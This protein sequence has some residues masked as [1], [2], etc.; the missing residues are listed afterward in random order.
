M[1]TKKT[2]P[3]NISQP[4]S[5][6]IYNFEGKDYV[7]KHDL[8]RLDYLQFW[9]DNPRTNLLNPPKAQNAF[10]QVFKEDSNVVDL[11]K[12]LRHQHQLE[13]LIV[14]R[15]SQNQFIV[16]EGNSRLAAMKLIC[17]EL[18]HRFPEAKCHVAPDRCPD[19]VLE[20]I[21]DERH[22]EDSPIKKWT[23]FGRGL[24][25]A[26][27]LKK[28][29]KL[30]LV[31]EIVNQDPQEILICIKTSKVLIKATPKGQE[32]DKERFSAVKAV[33]SFFQRQ[34]TFKRK[35]SYDCL[36]SIALDQNYGG[37]GTA[38]VFRNNIPKIAKATIEQIKKGLKNKNLPLILEKTKQSPVLVTS[39]KTKTALNKSQKKKSPHFVRKIRN[40]HLDLQSFQQ[41]LNFSKKTEKDEILRKQ[42]QSYIKRIFDLARTINSKLS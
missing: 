7:F 22:G 40:I 35:Q 27:L 23:P 36:I 41:E 15:I 9:T 3:V 30:S 6:F 34:T 28:Y 32:P 19:R 29:K 10:F 16:Y 13:P 33:H 21:V 8:V 14:K 2:G 38:T 11:Q 1:K 42:V 31:S 4:S 12:K 24:H 5:D 20:S 17:D 39:S 26:N 25:Y 18:P 37:Y